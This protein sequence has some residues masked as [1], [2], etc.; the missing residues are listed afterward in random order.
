[1]GLLVARGQA[2]I[3]SALDPIL[4]LVYINDLPENI[5]TQ[6]RLF[7]DK[8]AV[9]LTIEGASDSLILQNYLDRLSVWES[10][11]AH[12]F[13]AARVRRDLSTNALVS[14]TGSASG[15]PAQPDCAAFN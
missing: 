13:L 6:V 14:T 8:T 5:I 11:R 10:Q 4:F 3:G 15:E 2:H 12:S 9:Y 7:A 1:M